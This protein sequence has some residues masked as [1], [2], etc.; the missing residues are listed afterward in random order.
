MKSDSLSGKLSAPSSNIRSFAT[1]R[2]Q[3]RKDFKVENNGFKNNTEHNKS[4]VEIINGVKS[5]YSGMDALNV[6]IL[7]Y[8]LYYTSG[9]ALIGS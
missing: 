9:S 5:T 3:A 7:F 4:D 6:S 1:L 8:Y 2:E